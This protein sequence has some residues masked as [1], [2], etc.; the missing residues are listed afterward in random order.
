[1]LYAKKKILST[2]LNTR[3]NKQMPILNPKEPHKLES[4]F[5]ETLPQTERMISPRDATKA[6]LTPQS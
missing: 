3:N 6:K 1:M 4:F 2:D 5:F